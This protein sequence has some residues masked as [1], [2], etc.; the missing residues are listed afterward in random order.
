[1]TKFLRMVFLFGI[2]LLLAVPSAHAQLS[3]SGIPGFF[4]IKSGSQAPPGAYVSYIFLDYDTT[5]II[6]QDGRE[7]S[8]QQ[9]Q[10]GFDGHAPGLIAVTN[11]KIFGANYGVLAYIP[12]TNLAI[13][14]PRAGLTR[15]STFGASDLYVQPI[16]LGWHKKQTDIIAWY[17]LYAPT[18]RYNPGA[19]D[20]RGMGM[21]SHELALGSTY[22]FNEKRSFHASALGTLE[23]HSKKKDSD[24]QVG[25]ILMIQG[26]VGPHFD[27]DS[28]CRH[29]LLRAM[30]AQR[31]QRSGATRAGRW[32]PRKEPQLRAGPGGRARA[33]A[34]EG[35]EPGNDIQL[36]VH[37][38]RRH[39]IGHPGQYIA[40]LADV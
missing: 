31:R 37:L 32:P 29:D 11:Q 39:P 13:E 35:P 38:G 6:G 4:G 14:A 26:G 22:F 18:G 7:F 2:V 24:V 1:M 23:F 12:I 5:K 30:E 33:A 25:N 9:G 21:W 16:N 34:Q 20:N 36:P 28:R 17:G 15:S 19:N 10:I 8:F 40:R 27:A 3:G